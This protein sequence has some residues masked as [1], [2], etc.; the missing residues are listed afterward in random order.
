MDVSV[1][2]YALTSE[3]NGISEA[4]LAVYRNIPPGSSNWV[5]VAT[6]RNTGNDGGSYSYAEGDTPG[7]SNFLL[8][9]AD[10]TPTAIT[11]RAVGSQPNHTIYLVLIVGLFVLPGAIVVLIEFIKR[12]IRS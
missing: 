8:G 3:L 9:Q 6:N 2:L 7:F 10:T 5:E 1:R 4:N 11:L 12:R